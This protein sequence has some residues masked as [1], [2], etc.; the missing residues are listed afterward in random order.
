MPKLNL[1]IQDTTLNV[2]IPEE[3]IK[4][5]LAEVGLQGPPGPKGGASDIVTIT[6]DTQAVVNTSYIIDS[7][8]LVRVTLPEVC[9]TGDQV[10]VSTK[11]VGYW[12]IVQN[13]NQKIYVGDSSTTL[14]ITGRI[15]SID[16]G[17]SITIACITE[18]TEWIV[19]SLTGNVEVV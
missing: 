1:Y 7:P 3:V 14:G 10:G 18:N 15:D 8:A 17:V 4:V 11:G 6:S 13:P 2:L 19:I 9:R 5:E 16:N 12:R